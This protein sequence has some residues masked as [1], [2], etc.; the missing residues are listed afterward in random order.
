MAK[1]GV[2]I[3]WLIRRDMD[4]VLSIANES[5]EFPWSE[6]CFLE[7]LR[8]RNTI[9]MV[10]CLTPNEGNNIIT[11]FMI[12]ELEKGNLSLKN[13]AVK[14]EFR[15]QGVGTQMIEKL[16]G[17]LSFERRTSI[18]LEVTE[19]N[20]TAQLFFANQGFKAQGILYDW[21]EDPVRNAYSMQYELK[22][23]EDTLPTYKGN[24]IKK[25]LTEEAGE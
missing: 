15:R 21:Y 25:F 19:E 1:T 24:R 23:E 10:S 5:F 14:E 11:G 7:H 3:R 4:Q 13:F 18:S 8:M 17:K 16:T 22:A 12:Y 6:G 2:E 20:L 9:G